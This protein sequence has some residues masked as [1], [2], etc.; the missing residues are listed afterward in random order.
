MIDNIK[1]YADAEVLTKKMHKVIID[2]VIFYLDVLLPDKMSILPGS[3]PSGKSVAI[4][5]EG[6]FS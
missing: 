6:V 1:R 5:A 4:S 2:E 3:A